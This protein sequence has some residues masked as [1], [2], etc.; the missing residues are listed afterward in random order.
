[1]T[2]GRFCART[3]AWRPT[4]RFGNRLVTRAGETAANRTSLCAAASWLMLVG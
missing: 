3:T 1:M 2:A 4:T